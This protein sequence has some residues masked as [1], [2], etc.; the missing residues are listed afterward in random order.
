MNFLTFLIFI[1]FSNLVFA[2]ECLSWFI[3][4]G[5]TPKTEECQEKCLITP[6]DMS[7]FS[8]PLDCEELCS[9][10]TLEKMLKYAPRLTEGDK[11]LVANKPL[12]AFKVFQAKDKVDKLTKNIFGKMSREDESD[13]FRHFVWSVLLAKELGIKKAEIFLNAHEED[14]TQSKAEKEMDLFNNKKGI[15]FFKKSIESNN[16]LELSDIEKEGLNKLRN[17]Q[18]RVNKPRLK[19]IPGGYYSN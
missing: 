14:S 5:L 18:L 3:K 19:S 9:K 12:E 2:E 8:C 17:K 13:A 11:L 6:V 1:A 15:D 7:S 4:S 10:S 16:P